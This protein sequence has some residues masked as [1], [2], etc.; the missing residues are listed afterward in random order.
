MKRLLTLWFALACITANAQFNDTGEVKP[1]V[2]ELLRRNRSPVL[3]NGG[4][5]FI[6]FCDTND[7]KAVLTY[8][9]NTVEIHWENFKTD[10]LTNAINKL[11]ES[12]KFCEVR[13]HAW[14]ETSRFIPPG[15]VHQQ[16]ECANCKQIRQK[17]SP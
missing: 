5:N 8:T 13:G 12:G 2:Q 10:Q 11:V 4:T 14:C 9:T 3:T 17:A 15:V 16:T 1:W 6:I 7:Y